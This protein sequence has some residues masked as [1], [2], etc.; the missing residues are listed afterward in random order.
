MEL[1]N[2]LRQTRGP[3]LQDVGRFHFEKA[4]MSHRGDRLPPG[5]ARDRRLLHV[6]PAP[7]REDDLG[8][9]SRDVRRIHDAIAAESGVGELWKDRRPA[10]DLDELLDPADTGNE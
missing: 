1:P 7:R 2:A 9:A 10:G 5:T 3:W 8:I 4:L 6:L